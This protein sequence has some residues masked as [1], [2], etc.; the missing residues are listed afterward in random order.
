MSPQSTSHLFYWRRRV[1]D[2]VRRYHFS[3]RLYS[4]V[5]LQDLME[6]AGLEV[7]LFGDLSGTSY[8]ES[9]SRLIAL[10]RKV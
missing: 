5:E 6:D 4:G 8:D 3:H 2:A 9:A 1:R 7:S 10:G